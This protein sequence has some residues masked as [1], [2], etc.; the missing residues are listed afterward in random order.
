MSARI[1]ADKG[2]S[3]RWKDIPTEGL[4]ELS[5]SDRGGAFHGKPCMKLNIYFELA[6]QFLNQHTPE[7][8][9]FLDI[10]DDEFDR[11]FNKLEAHITSWSERKSDGR[12]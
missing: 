4:Y 3:M 2:V 8:R 5:D 1:L 11:L 9:E 12:T 6:Y 10:S 7:A